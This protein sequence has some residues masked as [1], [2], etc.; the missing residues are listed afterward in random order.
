[1]SFLRRAVIGQVQ[2]DFYELACHAFDPFKFDS[3]SMLLRLV[4]SD[5]ID[6]KLLITHHFKFDHIL[7][8]YE[9]F[10][11]VATTSALKEII[12]A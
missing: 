7:D 10:E 9:A 8:A 6:A 1:M 2:Y 11:H 12:K 5:R 3:T 4:Q